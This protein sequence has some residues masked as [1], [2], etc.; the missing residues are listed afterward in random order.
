LSAQGICHELVLLPTRTLFDRPE[1]R[2]ECPTTA[3]RRFVWEYFAT[4]RF[5]KVRVSQYGS[6]DVLVT[7]SN[8]IAIPAKDVK[9]V[10]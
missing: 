8:V 5:Y 9:N 6:A 7:N 1:L 3:Q 4:P 10:D 2:L